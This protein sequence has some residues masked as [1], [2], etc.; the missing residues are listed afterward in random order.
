MI[1]DVVQRSMALPSP[2]FVNIDG[3]PNFRHIG[4]YPTTAGYCTRRGLVYRSADF[5]KCTVK[6]LEQLESLEIATVFDLRSTHEVEK[7][8][9][10]SGN[11]Y[12]KLWTS[13]PNGPEYDFVPV[14]ADDD[15][16]PDA[17]LNRFKNYAREGTEVSYL[18]SSITHRK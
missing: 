8:E 1:I 18:R 2:P 4:G 11:K 13:M 7:A 9:E 15:Y 14:F 10:R 6:G 16:S 3:V 17:L 5:A 12:Y